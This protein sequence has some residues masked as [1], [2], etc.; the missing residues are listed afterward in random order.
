MVSLKKWQKAKEDYLKGDTISEIAERYGLAYDT[1]RKRRSAEKWKLER[2]AMQKEINEGL[3]KSINESLDKASSNMIDRAQRMAG[4]ACR[5]MDQIESAID[6]LTTETQRK[7]EKTIE[8]YEKGPGVG[9][10]KKETIIEKEEKIKGKT[11]SP[12]YTKLKQLSSALLDVKAVLDM[13]SGNDKEIKVVLPDE[14]KD[15]GR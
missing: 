12:N 6:D 2:D 10:A 7:K 15:W 8:Y 1:L 14:I 4:L 9:K 3:K 13:D 5:L 11:S